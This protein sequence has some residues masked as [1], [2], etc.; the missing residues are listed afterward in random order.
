[1]RKQKKTT[2]RGGISTEQAVFGTSVSS[3]AEPPALLLDIE[4]SPNF[5]VDG[6]TSD[7]L[8]SFFFTE[9]APTP[10]VEQAEPELA[11]P[12]VQI[13]PEQELEPGSEN[14]I[15]SGDDY[16]VIFSFPYSS[17]LYIPKGWMLLADDEHA[18]VQNAPG[19]LFGYSDPR[20]NTGR[21]I[22]KALMKDRQKKTAAVN[23]R[24]IDKLLHL[25][26]VPEEWTEDWYAMLTVYRDQKGVDQVRGIRKEGG[27]WVECFRSL[28]EEWLPNHH[29]IMSKSLMGVEAYKRV[30]L[31][32]F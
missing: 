2:S 4:V 22:Y 11:P 32:S 10:L 16:R 17:N 30:F 15:R 31:A 21:E 9:P 19:D 23:A 20:Q 24:V 12:V 14:K 29:I 7:E 25:N 6:L 3:E 1:M 13:E 18:S 27:E 26:D 5:K 28:D 8:E